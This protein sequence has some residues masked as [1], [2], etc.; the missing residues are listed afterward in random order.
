MINVLAEKLSGLYI[1][2]YD[3]LKW[4]LAGYDPEK[5]RALIRSLAFD[6]FEMVCRKGVP[7]ILDVGFDNETEFLFCRN[8]AGKHGYM[9]FDAGFTANREILLKRFRERVKS[10][11]K[12]KSKIALTDEKIFLEKLSNP[13]GVFMPSSTTIFDTSVL[14]A[15]AIGRE[16]LKMLSSSEER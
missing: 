5:D 10:A 15:E 12:A 3:K 16:I 13:C 7:I 14:P 6:F 1:V 2:S 8:M 9:F 11:Q 4:Q